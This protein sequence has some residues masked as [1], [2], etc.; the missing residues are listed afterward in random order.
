[1]LYC[2]MLSLGFLMISYLS[3]AGLSPLAISIARGV[4]ALSGLAATVIFPPMQRHAGVCWVRG[5]GSVHTGRGVGAQ[6]GSR[7]E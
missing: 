5:A 4:G 6:G 7:E 1:M 3:F 2:T